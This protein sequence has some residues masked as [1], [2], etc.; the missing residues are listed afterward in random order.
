MYA[1]GK[2]WDVSENSVK[3]FSKKQRCL[4]YYINIFSV[5]YD[6]HNDDRRLDKYF[7]VDSSRAYL[8]RVYY[9]MNN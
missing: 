1:F 4:Q 3:K 9:N 6:L 2:A 5:D 8:R 7:L